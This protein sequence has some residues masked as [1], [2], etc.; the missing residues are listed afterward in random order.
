MTARMG[1]GL[2]GWNH[3]VAWFSANSEAL[4][5]GALAA[6]AMIAMMLVLRSIGVRIT[7]ADPEYKSWKSVIGRVFAYTAFVGATL[8]SLWL[9]FGGGLADSVMNSSTP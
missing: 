3:L 5:I 8:F 7:E 4:L 9:I 6:A 1:R 2:Q